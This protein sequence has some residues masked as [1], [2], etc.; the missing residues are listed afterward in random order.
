M[1]GATLMVQG[2]GSSV[3]K[4]TLT[5]ALCRIFMQDGVRVAPFK[6]Q[7]MSNNAYV[8]P[9]GLELGRS[10]AV[11][12]AAAGIEPSS[13]MNPILLKPEGDGRSQVV[14]N[15]KAAGSF[16]ARAYYEGRDTLW[17]SVTSAL[18]RLRAQYDLV[19][20]EGAGSPVEV[21]LRDRDIVN[22][23][24]ALYCNAPVL[25]AAD[26]DRGGVFAS[27]LG[28]LELLRADER[29]LVKGLIINRFRGDRSL[30]EPLP[31]MIA[32]RTGVPV[33]GVVPMVPDLQVQ[34]ED[35]MSIEREKALG[36][37]GPMTAAVIRL[38]RISNFDDFDP[39]ARAGVGVRFV[40]DP[41]ELAGAHIVIIP[42]T[43][44]TIADLRWMRSRGLDTAIAAAAE[45]GT[46]VVGICGGY[47]M[48]GERLDDPDGADGGEPDSEPGLGLL[49][50]RT[51]FSRDKVTRRVE[52]RIAASAG[53]S[54]MAPGASG[55]GYE[56]HSGETKPAHGAVPHALLE[57]DRGDGVK[58]ADGA[59]S[60][61]GDVMG[62]YVHGLFDSPA[63]LGPFLAS[64]AR[65]YGLEPPV[66]RP[67]SMDAEFDRLAAVVRDSLDMD[68]IR[69][70]VGLG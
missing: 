44:H 59:V 49:P 23:E 20:M 69:G 65:R 42:G 43:K 12:A 16:R 60:P 61:G 17:Q 36:M 62:C 56:I 22:M 53:E 4:S 34:E 32:E 52:L 58:I 25:L 68:A 13:D 38:P 28:T 30:L 18:D 27:L 54:P 1:T 2:T 40:R 51:V 35:G 24:V 47:Q 31:Q 63:V 70:F 14:L 7:N 67:F 5:A 29:A 26:I 6:A 21:N 55:S 9:G 45:K 41:S 10:Q 8:T 39:L 11:Q 64:V 48:L 50:V 66:V 3:G 15:G 19:V 57:I 33:L 46:F 37:I